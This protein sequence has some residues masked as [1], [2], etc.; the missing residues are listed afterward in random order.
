M[1]AHANRSPEGRRKKSP[2]APVFSGGTTGGGEGQATPTG[3]AAHHAV[4]L[5]PRCQGTGWT[6]REDGIAAPCDCGVH[7]QRR[8]TELWEAADIPRRYHSKT[9]ESYATPDPLRAVARDFAHNWA[10]NFSLDRRQPGLV[11]RGST[12]VGKTH[13]AVAILREVALA[14]FSVLYSNTTDLLAQLRASYNDDSEID[15]NTILEEHARVDLLLLDDLGN[16]NTSGW[17]QDRMYLLIN[18]RYEN[19]SPTLVTTNCSEQ[20]LAEKL[21]PRI[22]SRLYEMCMPFPP[23]PPEDW[24][25]RT[26]RAQ[27]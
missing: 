24:R 21:G 10:M 26:L 16:E 5:C 9:F 8:A 27:G 7:E 3:A 4:D 23:F 22:A 13:L 17:V 25:I 14:G 1:S 6:L 11:I 2:A 20:E 15:E 18:R 19:Q 12:G